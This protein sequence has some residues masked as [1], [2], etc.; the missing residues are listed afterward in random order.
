MT[1]IVVFLDWNR[2]ICYHKSTNVIHLQQ[3]TRRM[4]IYI[5]AKT[6]MSKELKKLYKSA[7]VSIN[8]FFLKIVFKE[9]NSYISSHTYDSV[10]RE[11]KMMLETIN[12]ENLKD[13]VTTLF[14]EELKNGKYLL[15][16]SSADIYY[17]LRSGINEIFG[18]DNVELFEFYAGLI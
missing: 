4:P 8:Y 1:N 15:G 14:K 7:L 13:E 2:K 18:Y 9:D 5:L 11:L 6:I 10:R 16:K 17:S 12:K 3:K